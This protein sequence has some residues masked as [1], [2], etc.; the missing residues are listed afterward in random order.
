[1][2]KDKVF[3]VLAMIE[4]LFFYLGKLL[5]SPKLHAIS[6][7]KIVILKYLPNRDIQRIK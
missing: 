1:M 6:M 7:G 2:S 3:E 4:P 5:I